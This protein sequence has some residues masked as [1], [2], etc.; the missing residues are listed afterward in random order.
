MDITIKPN[1][2]RNYSSSTSNSS[3]SSSS[4]SRTISITITTTTTRSIRPGLNFDDFPFKLVME[5]GLM[6]ILAD[7][8]DPYAYQIQLPGKFH[9]SNF[10][11]C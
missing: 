1:Y 8:S 2:V 4:S 9:S 10:R 6:L 3:G 7:L 11:T 5:I